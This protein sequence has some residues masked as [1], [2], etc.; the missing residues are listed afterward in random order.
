MNKPFSQACEENKDPILK[1]LKE[2]IDYKKKR[3]L[4]V[5][6]GTGQHAFYFAS[7]FKHLEWYTSDIKDNHSCIIEWS[8]ESNTK[9]IKGP[10]KFQAGVDEFPRLQFD[11]VYTANTLHIMSWK[12][13]KTLLKKFGKHLR[14][15]SLVIIY[16][17]FNYNDNYTSE[18]NKSFDRMLKEKDPNSGIRSF[19][20][21]HNIMLSNN[22]KLIKDCEMPANNRTL[23]FKK[24]HK[25]LNTHFIKT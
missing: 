2:F 14:Q 25:C 11:V 22:F 21:I 12:E 10:L 17:P 13:V 24:N 9:N 3:L 23:V 4:E 7:H 18:S 5:G 16:G 1:V 6:S 19:E 20:N 15:D 8:K